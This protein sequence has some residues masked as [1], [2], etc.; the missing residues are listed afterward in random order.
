LPRDFSDCI[1]K[2]GKQRHGKATGESRGA[3][4]PESLG[5]QL[6]R[7]KSC[8]D[9][10]VLMALAP[11]SL[12]YGWLMVMLQFKHLDLYSST[13]IDVVETLVGIS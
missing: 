12:Y 9:T 1:G 11:S 2:G 5:T 13:G 3:G 4:A 6:L 10:L 8:L 7:G